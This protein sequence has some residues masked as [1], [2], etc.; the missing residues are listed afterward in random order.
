VISQFIANIVILITYYALIGTGFTISL[1]TRKVFD[2]TF[3]AIYTIAPYIVFSC[4]R[5]LNIPIFI[6]IIIGFSSTLL[7]AFFIEVAV[8]IP[9]RKHNASSLV[10][11]LA[12]LGLFVVVQNIISIIFGD[13]AR[14]LR[15][16]IVSEGHVVFGARLTSMQYLT[17]MI[18]IILIVGVM[19]FL[20]LTT[21]GKKMRA[22]SCD[23]EL[24]WAVGLQVDK[25]LL[26]SYLISTILVSTSSILMSFDT[27]LTPIMGLPALLI[28]VVV[29]VLGG[30]GKIIGVVAGSTLIAVAQQFGVWTIGSQWQDTIAFLIL[31]SFLLVRPEGFLGKKLGKVEA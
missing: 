14:T 29:C 23:R 7:I 21:L 26:A 15:N 13:E 1:H 9:M 12:S 18:S 20:Q 3:A 24:G 8:F 6:S 22:V 31:L 27:D 5:L 11:M 17:I 28:A 4:C 2:F 10:I 30:I 19:L 25:V 16:W